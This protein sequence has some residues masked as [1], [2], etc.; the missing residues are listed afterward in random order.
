MGSKP[1]MDDARGPTPHESR[2]AP[3]GSRSAADDLLHA[4]ARALRPWAWV[5]LLACLLLI[6]FIVNLFL[7]GTAVQAMTL[8]QTSGASQFWSVVLIILV[9]SLWAI[10][11]TAV[12]I[13]FRRWLRGA[14]GPVWRRAL[15]RIPRATAAI[16]ALAVGAMTFLVGSLWSTNLVLLLF[17][18]LTWTLIV[19]LSLRPPRL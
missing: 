16:M 6:V 4:Q 14:F 2:E 18:S 3:H 17:V 1:P 10:I 13:A 5:I 11:G 7:F 8:F 9:W 19:A 12:L 15:R